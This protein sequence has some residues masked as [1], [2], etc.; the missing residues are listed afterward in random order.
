MIA[1]SRSEAKGV[2]RTL[3]EETKSPVLGYFLPILGRGAR[4]VI[5]SARI[6]SLDPI[7]VKDPA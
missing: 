1:S 7:Q 3:F 4:V 2:R 5:T 6:L